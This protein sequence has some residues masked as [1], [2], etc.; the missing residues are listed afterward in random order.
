MNQQ[1]RITKEIFIKD[2]VNDFPE[3]IQYL[4]DKG[5]RCLVCGEPIWGTL[6]Q[7]SKEKKFD[8]NQIDI[9]VDDL[10]RLIF[11]SNLS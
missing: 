10:N 1:T 11:K 9:F 5:I 8:D 2:L 4:M 6:E 3:A 7:A